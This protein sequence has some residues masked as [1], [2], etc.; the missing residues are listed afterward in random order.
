MK[1]ATNEHKELIVSILS[2]AFDANPSVNYVVK[3]GSHRQHRIRKLMEYSF[4]MCLAFGE[5]WITDDDRGC[6]LV[7][8]PDKK[9]TSLKTIY[10]DIKLAITAIGLSRVGLVL[11]RESKIK[12]FHPRS[13]F[14]YLWFIGVDPNHQGKGIGSEL[15][16]S[17]IERFDQ[18]DRPIYVETSVETNLPWYK[19]ARFEVYGEL[20]FSYKLYLLRRPATR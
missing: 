11:K 3:Q 5:V 16:K 12:A 10:W 19:G 7:L 2:K 13:P 6:S 15:L 14:C 9:Q 20:S 1:Q 18:A 17:L 8:L 4:N